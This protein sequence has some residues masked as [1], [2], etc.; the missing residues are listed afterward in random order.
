DRR[1]RSTTRRPRTPAASAPQ[2]RC[3]CL[4]ASGETDTGRAYIERMRLRPR[5]L[6]FSTTDVSTVAG[7]RN[8][9]STMPLYLTE[10]DVTSLL[11]PADAVP[12]IE[13]SFRRLAGG[14]PVN[15]PRLRLPLDGGAHA[16][17]AAVDGGVGLAGSKTYSAVA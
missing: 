5:L 8:Y 14:A 3:G 17:M 13:E 10:H 4:S 15:Q 6:A 2:H 12:V 9:A 7:R 16:L 11:E 1:V